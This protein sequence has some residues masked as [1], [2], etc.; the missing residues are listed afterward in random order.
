V[1]LSQYKGKVVMVCFFLTTCPHCKDTAKI[2]EKLYKEYG[3]KGFQPLAVCIN[4]MAKML[5]ADFI[6]EQGLTFPCGYGLRDSAYAYLQHPTMLQLY[7]P[8]IAMVD[9]KWTIIGQYPGG[10]PIYGANLAQRETNLRKLVEDALKVGAAAP[11]KKAAS[12]KVS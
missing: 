2:V 1:L 9:R 10:D 11:A 12:K 4:D 3:A 6:K 8:T 5:T 7:M